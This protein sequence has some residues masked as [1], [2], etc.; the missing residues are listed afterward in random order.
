MPVNLSDLRTASVA[1][2][3]TSVACTIEHY[4]PDVPNALSPGEGFKFDV[5]AHNAGALRIARVKYHLFVTDSARAQLVVPGYPPNFPIYRAGLSDDSPRLSPG[6]RVSEMFIFP[7]DT[8]RRALEPGE[9]DVFTS[10]RGVALTLGKTD[11]R[12]LIHGQIDPEYLF[13]SLFGSRP[14]VLSLDIV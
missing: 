5:R 12:F 11:V 14:G 1:Y 2:L 10:L 9:A 4:A 7:L 13:P 3:A 6:S 8:D